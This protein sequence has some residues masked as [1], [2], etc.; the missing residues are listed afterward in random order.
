[1]PAPHRVSNWVTL[2][3]FSPSSSGILFV[4]PWLTALLTI[5][6][7]AY[8][9]LAWKDRWWGRVERIFYTLGTLATL[10]YTGFL[11]Y[12]QVLSL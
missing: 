5:G 2:F 12:S 11:L 1:M 9:V 10:C 4:L 3:G 7:L 8:T 6:L